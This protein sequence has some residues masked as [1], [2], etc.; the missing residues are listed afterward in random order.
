[1]IGVYCK[2]SNRGGYG[3]QHTWQWRLND[4]INAR[5]RTICELFQGS[6]ITK[7]LAKFGRAYY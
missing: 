1:V 7:A 5:I 3:L 6:L 4:Q 2:K